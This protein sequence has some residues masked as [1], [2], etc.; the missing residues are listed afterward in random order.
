MRPKEIPL[1]MIKIGYRY[2]LLALLGISSTCWATTPSNNIEPGYKT[3]PTPTSDS[4]FG[5]GFFLGAG[6]YPILSMPIMENANNR[7]DGSQFLDDVR[8]NRGSSISLDLR[9]KSKSYGLPIY[10]SGSWQRIATAPGTGIAT[11]ASYSRLGIDM[12]SSLALSREMVS[13]Q[14]SLEA[15]RAMYL[16]VDSGHYVDSIRLK[17]KLLVNSYRDLS[18]SFHYA[19]AP[20][21]KFGVLQTNTSTGSGVLS[22]SRAKVDEVGSSLTWLAPNQTSI[23]LSLTNERSII[24]LK[25]A[26]GYEAYGMPV[27]SDP[28]L[29]GPK[30]FRLSVRQ[31]S[32]GTVKHF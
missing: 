27:T 23:I 30:N 6:D 29:N 15:R 28:K 2:L 16:N 22:N 24:D 7:V 10:M 11:P 9:W 26:D 4:K 14:P 17:A 13:L 20:W 3:T 21:T 8:M 31:V 1:I 12:G 18:I 5:L 19:Y 32:L 25:N